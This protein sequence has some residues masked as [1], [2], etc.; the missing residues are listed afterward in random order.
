VAVRILD[1]LISAGQQSEA[2]IDIK[3]YGINRKRYH[4][5]HFTAGVAWNVASFL[6]LDEALNEAAS[7]I[8]LSGV[9]PSTAISAYLIVQVPTADLNE[10][11]FAVG[12]VQK[13]FREWC[14]AK[15]F[16]FEQRMETVVPDPTLQGS[17]HVILFLGGFDLNPLV[18]PFA[19]NVQSHIQVLARDDEGKEQAA[20]LQLL[21]ERLIKYVEDSD[22]TRRLFKE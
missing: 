1:G 6:N 20:T 3:D 13:A 16:H 8:M 7:N 17:Y 21:W 15:H 12:E 9:D 18:R 14:D 5:Q 19:T 10:P 22:E 2:V 11:A 4:F